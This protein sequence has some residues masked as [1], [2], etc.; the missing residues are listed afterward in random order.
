MHAC[1]S[2]VYTQE[3]SLGHFPQLLFDFFTL[4]QGISFLPGAHQQI[5]LSCLA[6]R[7]KGSSSLH[8][9]HSQPSNSSLH[10]A[11]IVTLGLYICAT[12]LTN[13][14]RRFPEVELGSSR[15][16]RNTLSTEPSSW[17]PTAFFSDRILLRTKKGVPSLVKDW[18]STTASLL[19]DLTGTCL[20]LQFFLL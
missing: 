4:R 19:P 12:M 2:C 16:N 9:H 14:L 7:S 5:Q 8:P 3:V 15:L 10:L 6:R 13:I 20:L 17:L 18:D 11:S 1:F